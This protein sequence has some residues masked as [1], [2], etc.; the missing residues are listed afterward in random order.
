MILYIMYGFI[1]SYNVLYR[2][3]Y[4]YGHWVYLVAADNLGNSQQVLTKGRHGGVL[5]RGALNHPKIEFH[6]Q[7][8]DI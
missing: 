8:G 3:P 6:Q 5:S 4:G 1:I 7:N 2:H